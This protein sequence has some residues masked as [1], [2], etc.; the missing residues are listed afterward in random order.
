MG[1]K[2][3]ALLLDLSE[4]CKRENLKSA[5]VGQDRTVPA[6]EPV[7]SAKLLNKL[8]TRANMEMVG[9]AKLNL[10]MNVLEVICVKSTLYRSAGC[11]ILKG[12]RFDRSVN[13]FEFTET[14]R[15]ALFY[16]FKLSA[17]RRRS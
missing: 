6:R 11:D 14:R 4:L 3:Y 2:G 10:G 9:V 1:G 13:R 16:N 8:I 17:L 5:A 7:E 15:S 12:R